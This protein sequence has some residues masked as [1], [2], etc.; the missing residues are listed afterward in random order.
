MRDQPFTIA[1]EPDDERALAAQIHDK[2]GE[3]N[4]NIAGHD[5]RRPLVIVARNVGGE[6]IGGLLGDLFWQVLAIHI[7]WVAAEQ[8]GQGIG[9]ALLAR[10]EAEA[11]TAGCLFAQVDTMDFQAPNF[12]VK[13]GYAVFGTVGPY[14]GKYTRYYLKKALESA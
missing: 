1:L 11:R 6:L 5:D 2:L 3:F 13:Y 9:A 4:F 8:R 7:L 12:Y 14:V 10:A